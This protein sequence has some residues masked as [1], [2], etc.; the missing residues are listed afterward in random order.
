[1]SK[2]CFVCQ[3]PIIKRLQVHP[4]YGKNMIVKQQ[5]YC[6]LDWQRVGKP[7]PEKVGYISKFKEDLS[8]L[9]DI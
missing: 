6:E 8:D 9:K 7:K 2:K 4:R 3:K 1:M 5:F